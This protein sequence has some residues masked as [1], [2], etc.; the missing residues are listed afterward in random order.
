MCFG[1]FQFNSVKLRTLIAVC[2]NDIFLFQNA[3]PANKLNQKT[4]RL[5]LINTNE[6]LT[7]S[8]RINKRNFY[9]TN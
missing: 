9:F 4:F 7:C 2:S 6:F 8:K 3:A 1:I 5:F